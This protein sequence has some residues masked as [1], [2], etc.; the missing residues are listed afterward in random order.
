MLPGRTLGEMNQPMVGGLP[1]GIVIASN[2]GPVAFQR[3]P[4]GELLARRGAG[5]LVTA[6]THIMVDTGGLWLASAMTPGDREVVKRHGA[7]P[8]EVPVE[9]GSLRLR[10]LTFERETFDRYYNRIS[11]WMFWLLQHSL[12][13]LP[14]HPRFDHQTRLS[15]E[16][17]RSVNHRFAEALAEEIGGQGRE[18]PVVLHDYHLMLVAPRLRTLVPDAFIYHFTHIPWCQPDM[19]RVLPARIG[20]ETL[21]GMLATDL[22]GFQTARWARNFMWCCHEL[23]QAEVDF[24]GGV[25]TYLDRAVRVRHYPISVDADA[26]RAVTIAPETVAFK[27]WVDEILEGRKLVLRI[28]RMELSKNIVRGL[29]AFEELLREHPEWRGRVTHLALLYPSRR[30]LWEYRAYE[31]EVLDTTDRINTELGTDDWQPIVLVNE[32]NYPRALAALTRYDVLLVNPIA[33]GMN[34]VSKEGPAVNRNDGVLVLSRNAGAWYELGH[35]AL[36][37]NPYDVSEMADALHSALTMQP[38]DRRNRA[39]LLREVV[40]RNNPWKWLGHQLDDI[41]PYLTRAP[42]PAESL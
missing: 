4:D 17:Y 8:V 36:T 39:D 13:N 40:E 9:H 23:L 10:Y 12:W 20:I 32:D 38:E 34:L 7:Q 15:W 42:R 6:L 33:D 25:V 5:G 27:A 18:R 31:A 35:A 24:A 1:E 19:M 22:L 3:G 2:R 41:L 29:R 11:N 14:E 30:A 21:E 26:L 37:V 28:D 16:A